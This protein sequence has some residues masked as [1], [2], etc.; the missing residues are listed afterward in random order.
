MELE[1]RT[2]A[3]DDTAELNETKNRWGKLRT[4]K[5]NQTINTTNTDTNGLGGFLSACSCGA[6]VT[7]IIQHK[8]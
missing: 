8:R 7:F 3:D 2:E 1:G 5:I 6:V 4:Q